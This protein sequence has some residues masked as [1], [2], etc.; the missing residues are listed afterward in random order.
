MLLALLHPRTTE[1][2]Q[3]G[4]YSLRK[5]FALTGTNFFSLIALR[6]TKTLT[7]LHS[8]WPKLWSFGHS[9]CNRVEFTMLERVSKMEI[10]E[11]LF[12][13]ITIRYSP[14]WKLLGGY[15]FNYVL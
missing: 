4:I 2:F 1:P 10:S 11:L 8:E 13:V 3:T 9:E 12:P 15:D 7:L 14:T 5:V 6:M